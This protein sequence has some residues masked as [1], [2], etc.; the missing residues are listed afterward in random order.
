M[1]LLASLSNRIFLTSALLAIVTTGVAIYAV[2]VRV[3]REAEIELQRGL[4]DAAQL[5]DQQRRALAAQLALSARLVADLPKFKGVVELQ[6]RPTVEPIARDYQRQLQ[7]DLFVVTGRTGARLADEWS[8]PGT[9]DLA[10]VAEALAGR[11]ATEFRQHPAGLLQ[12]VS[13]PV[14][15]GLEAPELLGALSV[16]VLLDER[17]ADRLKRATRSDVAFAVGGKVLAASLPRAAWAALGP[18]AERPGRARFVVGDEEYVLLTEPLTLGDERG[19]ATSP[20]PMA[21]VLQ[22]RTERLRFVRTINTAL[23]LAA[24]AAVLL[25]TVLSYGVAR[26]ITRPLGAITN[27]MREMAATGDLTRKITLRGRRFWQDE[28]ARLLAATFNTLTDSI[29]RFQRE[30]GQKERLLS[31][32]RLSTVIAHEVRNPL[33]IIKAALRSLTPQAP[34]DELGEAARDIDEEV[35]RLNRIVHDVLDFARPLRFERAPTD[36]GHLCSDAALAATGGESGP[37]V[38]VAVPDEPLVIA[39]DGERLRTALVNILANARQ[40]VLAGDDS[41]TATGAAERPSILL[42]LERRPDAARI[43]VVDRGIG[44]EAEHLPH[45]FE[46]YYT[47]KRSGTGLGLPIARN[48]I[49]GLGGTLA[50]RS[51]ARGTTVEIALPSPV[52]TPV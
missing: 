7:A 29:A 16:G 41:G 43:T 48:I 17:F 42:R 20:Q 1:K 39:T 44:I 40:A 3:T 11:E 28:D 37:I 9:L 46:P 38:Q 52:Q 47:T 6:H 27:A 32:G 14:S 31:L 50:I 8:A 12:V 33:M 25:A 4:T 5:V 21:V 36:L 45:I 2:G 51:D 10:S 24:V 35:A 49:E 30:A 26:T 34:P 18:L 13:V 19:L 23:L 22:S 15:I